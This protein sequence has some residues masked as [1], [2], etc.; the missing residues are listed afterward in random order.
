MC[1]RSLIANNF[2]MFA[3]EHTGIYGYSLSLFLSEECFNYVIVPGLEIKQSIG[4][5]REKNDK[6][7]AKR[8]ALYSY[9]KRDRLEPHVPSSESTVKLK[10][11]FSLRERMVKQRA[12]YKMSL[13]EQSEILSKTENKLLLKVQ[14]ELIKYLTKEIDIIEKEIKTIV[15]EDVGLKNQ[16]ELIT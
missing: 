1:P 7:D 10:R 3:M 6:G 16:Y 5:T 12:G 4:M 15:T 11:L 2:L 13:K 8:I 14:K 9:E